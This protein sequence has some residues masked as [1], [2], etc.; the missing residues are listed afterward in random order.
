MRENIE[1][2]INSG[3][4]AHTVA[5]DAGLPRNTVYRI[6]S[7][8]TEIGNVKFSTIEKLNEY[9]L[10]TIGNIE[11]IIM[12]IESGKVELTTT[13]PDFLKIDYDG[14]PSSEWIAHGIEGHEGLEVFFSEHDFVQ[15]VR[16]KIY[17]GETDELEIEEMVYNEY[18][19]RFN[20]DKIV[21]YRVDGGKIN[22][23]QNE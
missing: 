8:K 13:D 9:Y 19:D 21:A 10:D 7:G 12:E 5:V 11:D 18:A 16:Q 2:L 22:W 14:S 15:E 6:F 4:T 23:V 20:Y 17:D 3:I 1:I